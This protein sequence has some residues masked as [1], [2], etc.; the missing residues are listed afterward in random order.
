MQGRTCSMVRQ[1]ILPLKMDHPGIVLVTGDLGGPLDQ[2]VHAINDRP[3][4]SIVK[5]TDGPSLVPQTMQQV[6]SIFKTKILILKV[7]PQWKNSTV[8][9]NHV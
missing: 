4:V 9:N 3:I 7:S 8:A 2:L 5:D 6:P 1:Y